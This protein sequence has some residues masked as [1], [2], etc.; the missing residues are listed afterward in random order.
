MAL[1]V[2]LD[3]IKRGYNDIIGVPDGEQPYEG[4]TLVLRGSDSHY[5]ADDM[6][7]TL[8]D[9]LPRARVV[10]LKNAG[11]WLHA[12]KPDAFQQAV[13]AFIAAQ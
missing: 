12:D 9:V 6:L 8:R 3:H 5:V 10:T 7:P 13:M 1:R 4:P 2:G 11:H